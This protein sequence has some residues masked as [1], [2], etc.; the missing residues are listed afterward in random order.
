MLFVLLVDRGVANYTECSP[1]IVGKSYRRRLAGTVK[2]ITGS[3]RRQS[4][5]TTIV[6]S[7]HWAE[8]GIHRANRYANSIDKAYFPKTIHL[9]PFF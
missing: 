3:V 6:G 5:L 1:S 8:Q 2:S 9:D 4:R 7:A